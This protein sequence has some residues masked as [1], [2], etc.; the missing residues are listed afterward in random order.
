[1][2]GGNQRLF[3]IPSTECHNQ[4]LHFVD[5]VTDALIRGDVSKVEHTKIIDDIYEEFCQELDKDKNAKAAENSELATLNY[6]ELLSNNHVNTEKLSEETERTTDKLVTLSSSDNFPDT[7]LTSI[8]TKK[9]FENIESTTTTISFQLEQ[10]NSKITTENQ[11]NIESMS[12]KDKY[13]N[14]FIYNLKP[15][16]FSEVY[17]KT[18][19]QKN[20]SSTTSLRP[21][22]S[23]KL[24]EEISTVDCEELWL[25]FYVLAAV[26]CA[27]LICC[28][29]SHWPPFRK[30]FRCFK[31][32]CQLTNPLQKRGSQ[33]KDINVVALI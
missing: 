28:L 19:M 13:I 21:L 31:H 1:M 6:V 22:P 9:S 26:S 25:A 32:L 3:Y 5:K 11:V 4:G 2:G 27:F 14:V 29:C 20:S 23:V 15:F 12:T 8:S 16:S 17:L 24:R 18:S 33:V 30:Y 10:E 7:S